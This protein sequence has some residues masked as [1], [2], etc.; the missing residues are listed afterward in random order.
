MNILAFL[1]GNSQEHCRKIIKISKIV[2]KNCLFYGV[3]SKTFSKT[4]NVERACHYGHWYVKTKWWVALWS[5]LLSAAAL[6]SALLTALLK[7]RTKGR[8]PL[9]SSQTN[10]RNDFLKINL[11]FGGFKQCFK[12]S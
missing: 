1:G 11:N 9:R 7:G 10:G 5:A 6:W 2:L 8:P 4:W 3:F 12:S